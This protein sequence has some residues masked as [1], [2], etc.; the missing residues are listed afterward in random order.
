[1]Q[2]RGRERG[3][4]SAAARPREPVRDRSIRASVVGAT[5]YT[6]GE[7]LRW[8]RGHP[9]VEIVHLTSRSWAE[10]PVTE[11]WPALRGLEERLLVDPDPETLATASDIVLLAVPHGAGMELAAALLEREVRVIDLSA[12]FRLSDPAL[13][14]RWY[15][16]D[17]AAPELLSEAVYGLPELRRDAV[18][19]A[20]LVANPGCYPTAT[21]LALLPLVRAGLV[22][23][24]VSVD[25]KSG[26][27]GAGRGPAAHTSFVEVNE[28]VRPYG[29]GEHR[30]TPEIEGALGVVGF[31]EGVF[32]TP[33]LVPMSRGILAACHVR[34]SR[35]VEG[36]EARGIYREA[37]EH[38]PFVRVLEDG[39]PETRATLG[40]NFCDVAVRVDPE[41]RVGVA[42]AAIDNLGKGAA[43]QAVQNLNR[44]FDLD[45]R[46]GL[47]SAPTF[48]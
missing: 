40:S 8:L 48:P 12:D 42:L 17:H 4:T 31:D 13:Y 22:E 14:R 9:A 38:E 7:L 27:S 39:L 37:Y 35:P 10:R 11:A 6:G 18:A 23:G 44:M 30:H 20:R 43:S 34:L 16:R 24:A 32:F 2:E 36:D 41:R 19:G 29:V 26:A 1:M 47:W 25:A 15:G 33:H 45:E 3:A 28:N 5:G 46:E 21:L